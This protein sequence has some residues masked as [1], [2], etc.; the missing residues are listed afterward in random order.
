MTVEAL[1]QTVIF[2]DFIIQRVFDFT[3]A[4]TDA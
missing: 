4:V 1:D 2:D 3:G